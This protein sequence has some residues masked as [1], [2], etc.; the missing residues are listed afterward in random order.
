MLKLL[1]KLLWFFVKWFIIF[2]LIPIFS[3]IG[4]MTLL[5]IGAFSGLARG[6]NR[7]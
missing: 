7:L 4:L 3:Y 5:I 1:G 6:A 2:S